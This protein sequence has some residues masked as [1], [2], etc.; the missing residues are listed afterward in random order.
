MKTF[1]SFLIP[2]VSFAAAW[3]ITFFVSRRHHSAR[4]EPETVIRNSGSSTQRSREAPR[5]IS[6][7]KLAEDFQTHPL[8]EWSKLWEEFA[9]Q[10]T[11]SELQNL[12]KLA[13]GGRNQYDNPD[14]D[15]LKILGREELAIR[16]GR[17]VELAPEAFSALAE[18]DP[19]TAWKN[20][21]Q[22]NRH[23]YATAALR[24]LASHDPE[25]ALRRFQDMPISAEEPLGDGGRAE[26]RRAA[27][28]PTPL[29]AIFGAWARRDPAAAAAAVMKLPPAYRNEAA[30]NVAM[31]WSFQDG[32]AAIRY[33]LDFTKSGEGLESRQ[34]RLDSVL[35]AS[36]R[37]HPAETAKLMENPRLRLAIDKLP[38]DYVALGPWAAADPEGV[39]GWLLEPAGD[40]HNRSYSLT[41]LLDGEPQTA[42]RILRGLAAAGTS[43]SI[44]QILSIH[45]RDPELAL[46]LAN[47]LG[48][49]LQNSPELKL[50]QW[51]DDPGA[52]INRWLEEL[53]KNG[54]P[55]RALAELGWTKEIATELAA[56]AARAFPGKAAQLAKLV[57]AASLDTAELWRRNHHDM[58]RY[59]PEL[60][61]FL[62]Y[63]K[64]QEN[65][66]RIP[67]FE[68]SQFQLDPAAAAEQMLSRQPS[69]DDVTEA[70]EIWAPH[71]PVAAR[72]WL[73]RISDPEARQKG[74]LALAEIQAP[75]DPLSVLT[76]LTSQT[77]PDDSTSDL[78][79]TSLHR[80]A[81]NGG[82][83][84]GW[85]AR[86]PASMD[87]DRTELE[88]SL[89]DELKL[90]D[91][92]RRAA[93]N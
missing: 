21:A 30:S 49:D 87:S 72:A 79:K 61:P 77:L 54:N 22:H 45:C 75:R 8:S 84:K 38:C 15:I 48:M 7:E 1:R 89:T 41:D 71:D 67:A 12:P 39:V 6:T 3:G 35:R 58:I 32:P 44:K 83:W 29:G 16:A 37:T 81:L 73:T 64:S 47:E 74:E 76:F 5:K 11:A 13:A 60:E 31:T 52:S 2:A 53:R 26:G 18:R 93:G 56:R 34:I 4:E 90:L 27:V 46:S 42:A 9:I 36:F 40:D 62:A 10:A 88:E 86:M 80:L 68:E 66:G 91:L 25:E 14:Q 17:P 55:D 19:E 70:V 23:D 69:A 43:V 63:P 57:P 65:G 20:F 33:L 59:W 92:A 51:E 24:T 50:C 28:W 78:W 85:L 82:D